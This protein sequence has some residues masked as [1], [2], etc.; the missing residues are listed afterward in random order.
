MVDTLHLVRRVRLVA[1]DALVAAQ[2]L[3]ARAE[4]DAV[5]AGLT[6]CD[7]GT[8]LP[9]PPRLLPQDAPEHVVADAHRTR[10][11]QVETA[12]HVQACA[13]Q[14]LL[15]ADEADADAAHALR[16][17]WEA[18]ADGSVTDATDHALMDAVLLSGV[19][20]SGTAAEVAAWWASLTPEAQEMML[21]REWAR[22]A[23][24]DGVPYPVRIRANRL[25]ISAE[26]AA[27]RQR[28]AGL[29]AQKRDLERQVAALRDSGR[30]DPALEAE[31]GDLWQQWARL[32]FAQESS[33][34]QS[35]WYQALLAAD[36]PRQV[37]LF[38]PAGGRY[39]EVVGDLA[40]ATSVG[41]LV[42]GTGAHV[43]PDDGTYA[44]AQGF[45]KG[46][47]EDDRLA[48]ITFIGGPMPEHL[49]LDSTRN[50]FADQIGPRLARFTAG[51][52]HAPGATVTVVGH[53]YG[54]SIV[55][56]AEASG[57][58]VD[59]ILHVES[60][61]I[62]AGVFTP[63]DLPYP[64][65]PR[66]SMTAPGDPIAG[67]QGVHVQGIGHG[68]DPDTFPGVTRL[69]TGLVD[70][71]DTG[72]GLLHGL[73]SHTDVLTPKSTAWNNMLAVM[74]GGE[75]T[76]HAPPQ[77]VATPYGDVSDNP[78]DNPGFQPERRDI[79]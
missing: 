27:E 5:S 60:A 16:V 39:A 54:G 79:P 12:E 57:M 50:S 52:D 72:S 37:V 7:D 23:D 15:A 73:D 6:L 71:E 42:P 65:T 20:R 44:R 41:V 58:R 10:I 28:W 49:L 30:T 9:P 67:T 33:R 4:Q 68:A 24:L 11:V 59:R 77:V 56:A 3:L 76:L 1:C 35:D 53:S 74:T 34:V 17:A 38:D 18:A 19:P 13:R 46:A 66:Y 14:A 31:I 61:G 45:V 22:I 47:S 62:G 75:V 43:G 64:D 2:A 25:A 40:T 32:D 26:L 8:V 69:E 55:G 51:V 36:P 48:V 21:E 63:E 78:M 70:D 29:D